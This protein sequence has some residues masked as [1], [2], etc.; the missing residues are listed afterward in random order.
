MITY[1]T[2]LKCGNETVV[3]HACDEKDR[4]IATLKAANTELKHRLEI[5]YEA[6][7]EAGYMEAKNEFE[8]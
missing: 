2:C 1:L 8:T 3:C 6:G 5:E 4:R 7:Y